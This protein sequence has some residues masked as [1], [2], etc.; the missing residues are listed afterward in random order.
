KARRHGGVGVPRGRQDRI[1]PARNLR[2]RGAVRQA[3]RSAL[4]HREGWQAASG[5]RSGRR[6]RRPARDGSQ[7]H[8]IRGRGRQSAACTEMKSRVESQKSKVEASAAEVP[9]A[10]E[11]AGVKGRIRVHPAGYGFVER[12]DGEDDVFVAARDR[13]AAMDGDRVEVLTWAGYKGTE[14]RV[15][16]ILERGRAKLTGTLRQEGRRALLQ[17]DDPR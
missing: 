2:W 5:G 7:W 1:G 14:G 4:L 3:G 15:V 6:R 9:A 17:P 12:D 11:K 13:G 16:R 10:V 8:H